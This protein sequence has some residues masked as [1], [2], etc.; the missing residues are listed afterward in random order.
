MVA[1]LCIRVDMAGEVIGTEIGEAGV[2]VGEKVP[3][4]DQDGACDSDD[5]AFLAAPSGYA[6]VPLAQEAVVPRR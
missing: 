4:D 6:S 2:F 3:D 1:F 5:R